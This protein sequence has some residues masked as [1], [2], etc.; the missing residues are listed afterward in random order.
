MT[1]LFIYPFKFQV[2]NEPF[3]LY[4]DDVPH[5]KQHWSGLQ[6]RVEHFLTSPLNI[7][8]RLWEVQLSTGPLGSSGAIPPC[9]VLS[10]SLHKSF[11]SETVALFRMHHALADG[12]SIGVAIGDSTDEADDLHQIVQSKIE[13]GKE[14]AKGRS[15]VETVRLLFLVLLHY[16]LGTAKALSLQAWRSF[17]AT[18]RP[19]DDVISQSN[20]PA[21]A[22]SVT[23]RIVAPVSEIK[24]IAKST[25][26]SATI[27]D[28]LVAMVM[29]AVWKQLQEHQKLSE[30]RRIPKGGGGQAIWVP[31]HVNITIP[32]HLNGGV[33]L[34]GETLGNKIGAFVTSVPLGGENV[35][36]LRGKEEGC[37]QR[38]VGISTALRGGKSTTAPLIAWTIAKI[39]SDWAP[40][41][42]T[43]WA[44][45]NFNAKSVAVIS[46]VKGFPFKVHWLGRPLELF[47]AFLPLPPGIPIGVVISS[48][49]GEISFTVDADKRAVPD[50]DRFG[51]W[52]AEEYVRMKRE[53]CY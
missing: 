52:M 44:I 33:L 51:D 53:T 46:N 7:N 31:S 13:K 32:V 45:E 41:P 11:P 26:K 16:I 3:D 35:D 47:C 8:K 28:V 2:V 30:E 37:L 22:R 10:R 14:K 43:K 5:P 12:V 38:L 9:R 21:G 40:T 34:P 1:S 24:Q 6:K 49:D 18:T 23:W 15:L 48:Y 17:R 39:L 36:S 50:A 25:L 4:A 20:I 19:F 27:N 42:L 29:H